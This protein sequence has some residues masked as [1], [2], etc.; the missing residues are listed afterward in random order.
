MCE[1]ISLLNQLR[2]DG[3]SSQKGDEVVLDIESND[4]VHRWRL[5]SLGK[6]YVREHKE[7]I[8]PSKKHPE[9]E[10][11]VRHAHC[12]NNPPHK[13]KKGEDEPQDALS[14]DELHT[15]AD[16]YF[17]N[18]LGPPKA[19]VFKYPRADEFDQHIRGWTLYWNE[20]FEPKDLLDPNLVKALIA[21]ESSF[22]PEQNTPNHN[23]K[24]GYARGLMQITDETIRILHGH[25]VGLKN[26]FIYIIHKDANDPSA[27]ICA[28][29]RW[30][31]LKRAGAKERY[32]NAGVY[33][34]IVT[35]DD[36]VAEYK[37][38]LNGILDE[39]NSN[40]DPEQK[41]PKFRALYKQIQES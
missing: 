14:I 4:K 36:A 37:G 3:M 22:K 19:H 31:F 24:I 28:G 27:N 21:S 16:A 25:E 6:H 8:P 15:I 32:I 41:M 20:V 7:H 12:A 10:V 11:I 38:V 39:N 34:H 29:I 30:L 1:M 13:N 40:P 9:G 5:C 18:L 2:R 33:D 17:S 35:W 23:K 26:H